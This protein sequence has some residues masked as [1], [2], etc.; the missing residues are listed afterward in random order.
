MT[1]GGKWR[2]FAVCLVSLWQ[3]NGNEDDHEIC[4]NGRRNETL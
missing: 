2:I 4:S 3:D 1:G